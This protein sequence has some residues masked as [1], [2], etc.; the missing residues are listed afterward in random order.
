MNRKK[1]LAIFIFTI[2]TTGLIMVMLLLIGSMMPSARSDA[3]LPR[4][5]ISGLQRGRLSILDGPSLG[6]FFNGYEIK[7]LGYKSVD[8]LFKVWRSLL[9]TALLVCLIC[10]GGNLST[11]VLNLK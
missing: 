6:E 9:K 1:V 4:F 5:D 7:L 8:G 10:T 2:I 3:A 11:T